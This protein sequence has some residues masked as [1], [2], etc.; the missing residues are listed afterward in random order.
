MERKVWPY[1]RPTSNLLLAENLARSSIPS[2]IFCWLFAPKPFRGATSL[3]SQTRFK[4]ATDNTPNSSCRNLI[5]FGP[6]PGIPSISIK[7]GGVLVCKSIQSSGQV[8]SDTASEMAVPRPFP[9]PFRSKISPL[10]TNSPK[11]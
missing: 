9:I 4:S 2:R 11:S 7:P 3:S 8:P 1:L 5:F 10:S 6:T